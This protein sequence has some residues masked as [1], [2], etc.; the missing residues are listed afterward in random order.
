M[1]TI[2]NNQYIIKSVGLTRADSTAGARK[3]K[4]AAF[5]HETQNSR[6]SKEAQEMIHDDCF[7]VTQ[8]SCVFEK[9][10]TEGFNTDWYI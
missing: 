10:L 4:T 2:L 6:S 9:L 8:M 1:K 7:W 3:K 5:V